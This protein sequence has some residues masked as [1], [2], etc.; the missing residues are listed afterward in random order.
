MWLRIKWRFEQI[1]IPISVKLTILY[2]AILLGIL[3]VTSVLTIGSMQHS[4]EKQA[5]DD[6]ELSHKNVITYLNAGNPIDNNL[7][8]HNLLQ[9]GVALMIYDH[10]GNLIFDSPNFSGER[11]LHR[12]EE[13]DHGALNQNQD[14]LKMERHPLM[15]H[16]G[17]Y[18]QQMEGPGQRIFQYRIDMTAQSF[19]MKIL[20]GSLAA[21]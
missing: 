13:K 18:Y 3:I 17:Y 16:D 21:T 20:G 6:I 15:D 12:A 8:K 1:T 5:R 2:S 10:Q 4:L 14:E 11:R 19:F 9:A 7:L